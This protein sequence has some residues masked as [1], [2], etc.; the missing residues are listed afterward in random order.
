MDHPDDRIR[1]LEA[2]LGSPTLGEDPYLQKELVV[3]LKRCW[4][5]LGSGSREDFTRSVAARVPRCALSE[6]PE[7]LLLAI[8]K[9]SEEDIRRSLLLLPTRGQDYHCLPEEKLYLEVPGWLGRY[10]SYAKWNY[11]PLGFHFWSA[12]A[13]LGAVC[14]RRVYFDAGQFF[15]LPNWYL[16]LVGDSATGKSA[17]A[18]TALDLLKRLNRQICPSENK[19][20]RLPYGRQFV[21]L[22]PGDV[23]VPRACEILGHLRYNPRPHGGP[24]ADGTVLLPASDGPVDATAF[25]YID[26]VANFLGRDAYAPTEK[27]AWLTE[28]KEVDEYKKST[29]GGGDVVLRNCSLSMVGCCAPSWLKGV[30]DPTVLGG[31]LADRTTYVF[32]EPVWER[33]LQYSPFHLQGIPKDPILAEILASEL[34]GVSQLEGK[35]TPELS[36]KLGDHGHTLY[37]QLV[38]EEKQRYDAYGS[39]DD[40]TSSSRGFN[41]VLRLSTLF[42]LSETLGTHL[43]PRLEITKDHIELAFQIV[44]QEEKSF[45]RFLERSTE[46]PMDVLEHK[47]W[48]ALRTLKEEDRCVLRSEFF[49]RLLRGQRVA[50]VVPVVKEFVERGVMETVRLGHGER[51]RATHHLCEHCRRGILMEAKELKW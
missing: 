15:I 28:M 19:E 4:P 13:A 26:E 38:E 6:R 27:V 23:T 16:F 40:M 10:L 51:W 8:L 34:L 11:V 7:T 44:R 47:V 25:L 39:T 18:T 5:A 50:K 22:L 30:I 9:L 32:R 46:G 48:T 3:Q 24:Q 14:Q 49:T 42:A 41:D 12:V 2:L 31:G 21:N 33:K 43:W 45:R 37:R 1:H 20:D 29:K 17:A 35:K 36:P